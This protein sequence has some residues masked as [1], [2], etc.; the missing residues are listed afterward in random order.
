[1]LQRRLFL[2]HDVMMCCRELF[3]FHDVQLVAERAV[4]VSWC[5]DV[6]QK[7]L[8]LFHDVRTCYTCREGCFC[9]MM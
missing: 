4:L 9:F 2:F 6:L 7:R 3:L 5:D 8:F 1:M